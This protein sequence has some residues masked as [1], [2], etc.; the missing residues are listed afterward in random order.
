MYPSR[1]LPQF[2]LR[3]GSAELK[4]WV[5]EQAKTNHR[6]MNAE[7]NYHLEQA[8]FKQKENNHVQNTD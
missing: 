4:Q 1:A 6:S 7:I 3:I 2:K 5:A 8:M